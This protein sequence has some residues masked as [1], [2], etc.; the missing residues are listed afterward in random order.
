MPEADNTAS[1]RHLTVAES[2]IGKVSMCPECA[3]IHLA[4]AHV[5]LRL[6][7]DVFNAL[8]QMLRQARAL[9]DPAALTEARVPVVA[10]TNVRLH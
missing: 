9:L 1:C 2:P 3:V 8:E 4:I 7:P 5:T 6:T 10:S